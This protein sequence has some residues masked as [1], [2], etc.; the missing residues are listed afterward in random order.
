MNNKTLNVLLLIYNNAKILFIF[1]SNV[2]M[3]YESLECDNNTLLFHI[4]IRS[5]FYIP[6]TAH[7]NNLIR[8]IPK[9]LGMLKLG[10]TMG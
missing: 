10:M 5:Y 2:T 6:G 1:I 8:I 4:K 3:I 9:E 7:G